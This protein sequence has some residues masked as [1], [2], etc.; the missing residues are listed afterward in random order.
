MSKFRII[1]TEPSQ[2]KEQI[3]E[4]WRN[5]L[6]GTPPKRFEWMNHGNPAGPAVWFFALEETS[7]ELAGTLSLTP[8]NIVTNGRTIRACILGD[9]MV[10]TRYRVYGPNLQLMRAVPAELARLGFKLA[11]TVP[12]AHSEQ[13]L[14]RIGMK[15]VG[16][17]KI[18]V[19]PLNGGYYLAKY[20]KMNSFLRS[21]LT[22]VINAGLRMASKETYITSKGIFEEITRGEELPDS[23]WNS[24][25]DNFSFTGERSPAYLEWKYFQ[26]PFKDFH[27]IAFR[28]SA[29]RGPSGYIV[30]RIDQNILKIYDII[31][32]NK[33]AF[34]MLLNKVIDIGRG[35]DCISV[36]V[37]IFEKNPLLTKFKY[38]GFFNATNTKWY[39]PIYSM[40]EEQWSD[41]GS[42]LF[43]SDRN[44]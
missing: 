26:N 37:D 18:L 15:K 6:P 5:Y 30:Y 29:G 13:L 19:K 24:V 40:G 11:Y 12:N 4:F 43:G 17:F 34:E 16:A 8:K 42:Y 36:R 38:F 9:L 2:F 31:A 14:I 1:Q 44:L 7:K 20:S 10:D 27:V 25:R 23:L 22:P 35:K 39:C 21:L 28:H 41:N 32:L 3:L 33:T